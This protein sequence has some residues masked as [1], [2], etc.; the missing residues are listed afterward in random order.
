MAITP[1]GIAVVYT[2]KNTW[3]DETESHYLDEIF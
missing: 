1:C 3:Y 2:T